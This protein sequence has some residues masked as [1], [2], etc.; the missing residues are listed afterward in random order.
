[1]DTFAEMRT[2]SWNETTDTFG[3]VLHITELSG[4]N[5][6]GRGH[7]PS[8]DRRIETEATGR[9]GSGNHK[10]TAALPPYISDLAIRRFFASF[11]EGEAL[12]E[13]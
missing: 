3:L 6:I 7:F 4:V 12:S 11:R 10:L 9:V 5:T 1:M 13:P 8:S 2:V